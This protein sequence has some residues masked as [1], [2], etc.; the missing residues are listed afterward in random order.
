MPSPAT[1]PLVLIADDHRDT[2]EMYGVYLGDLGYRVETAENGRDAVAKARARQPD[3]IVMDLSMPGVDGWAAI[4]QLQAEP[5]TARIPIVVL[6][7]HDLRAHLKPAAIA[8]GACS[9]FM[10]P[11]PPENLAR[12]VAARVAQ[13]ARS[14]RAPPAE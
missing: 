1:A 2:R 7:G 4:G 13:A 9:F 10:K 14:R 12:E 5:Q 3:A 8:A 6:T 11:C